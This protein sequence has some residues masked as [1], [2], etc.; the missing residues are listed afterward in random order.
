VRDPL[1]ALGCQDPV[2]RIAEAKER[3]SRRQAIAD[4]FAA[5]LQRHGS[6]PVAPSKLHEDVVR[7]ADPQGRGRQFLAAYLQRLD[8]TRLKG[9]VLTRQESVGKHGHATYALMPTEEHGGHGGD[10][11]QSEPM[12]P[13]PPMV[14][15]P[16]AARWRG[17][18]K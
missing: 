18:I 5:W 9:H 1:V 2:Q 16:K 6:E 4:L 14:S 12:P 8:G 10:A 13:M 17:R 15:G 11:T 7:L 3:D